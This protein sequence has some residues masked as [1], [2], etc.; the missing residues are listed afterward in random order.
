MCMIAGHTKMR[1][2][3]NVYDS[4]HTFAGRVEYVDMKRCLWLA[5]DMAA[6]P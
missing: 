5:Y 3:F 4:S 6:M 2:I 1:L